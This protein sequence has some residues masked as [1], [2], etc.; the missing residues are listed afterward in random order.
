MWDNLLD[1]LFLL[2]AE[3]DVTFVR[4]LMVAVCLF[5]PAV[6]FIVWSCLSLGKGHFFIAVFLLIASSYAIGAAAAFAVNPMDLAPAYCGSLYGLA[7]AMGAL[8]GVFVA[9]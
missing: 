3:Y 2:P 5:V 9:H 6:L 4:K 8:S 1:S 7:N